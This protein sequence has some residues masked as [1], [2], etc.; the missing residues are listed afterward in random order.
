M[1]SWLVSQVRILTFI[2]LLVLYYLDLCLISKAFAI[3][4]KIYF[5]E[6]LYFM[7]H[8]KPL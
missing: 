6:K 1:F 4:K 8:T 3:L 7:L 5:S 2:Q